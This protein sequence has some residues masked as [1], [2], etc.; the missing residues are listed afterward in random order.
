MSATSGRLRLAVVQADLGGEREENLEIA[1]HWLRAAAAENAQVVLLPE[2]FDG[3]YFPRMVDE[4]N[5]ARAL[6]AD[7]HPTIARVAALAAELAVVVPVSFYELDGDRHFNSVAMID[8]D[9]TTCGVYRKSHIPAG[10][11]YEEKLC[12]VPGDTGFRVWRTRYGRIGVGICWDQWFPE[13][14]RAMTLAGAELLLYPSTIGSEPEDA[15]LDTRDSWRR[16]MVGHAVANAIP[17]AAANRVGSEGELRFYGSS[18]VADHRG[19]FIAELDR[20][21]PGFV[22]CDVD[23]AAAHAYRR[24][25][26]FLRDRRPDLYGSLV[27]ERETE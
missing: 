18:F 2:L 6:P 9:G 26:G 3:P 27:A 16:V 5:L 15:Q 21:D 4:A 25:W 23:L 10:T 24:S 11:G 13:A 17:L 7:G 12:F 8:A 22:V 1:E 19:D 20:D 14:A